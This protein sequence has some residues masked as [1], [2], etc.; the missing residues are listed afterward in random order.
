M[1]K[2]LALGIGLCAIALPLRSHA[3]H[4]LDRFDWHPVSQPIRLVAGQ[5]FEASFIADQSNGFQLVLSTARSPQH[6]QQRCRMDIDI[7]SHSVA[8]REFPRELDIWWAIRSDNEIL[9]EGNYS[10]LYEYSA[11]FLF[12]ISGQFS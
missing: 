6:E 11:H 1:K 7:L 10:K 8:C 3:H 4:L 2:L 5:S 12:V 9:A